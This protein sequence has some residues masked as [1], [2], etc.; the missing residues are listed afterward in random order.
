MGDLVGHI[1]LLGELQQAVLQKASHNLLLH[2]G[3]GTQKSYRHNVF[4]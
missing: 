3:N 4:D 2:F 1:R